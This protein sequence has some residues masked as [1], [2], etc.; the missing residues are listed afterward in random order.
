MVTV[1]RKAKLQG[2]VGERGLGMELRHYREKA[3]LS[4]ERVGEVLG[5]SANTMSRLERGLRPDT[6]TDEVSAILAAIEVYGDD[7][8]RLMRMAVGYSTQG[9]WEGTP[10]LSD[11]ARIYL[12]F[13]TRATR[14]VNVEPLLVPGLLQAPDYMHSLLLAFGVDKSQI[15]GRIARRLG[16]QEIL[17]RR[18]PPELVFVVCERALRDPLGGHV[19][20]ARQ[21][22]HMAEQAERPNVSIRIIPT[23]VVAHP[24][25]RGAFVVLEFDGESPVV[26]IEGRR[27]G[28]FPE[29]PAEVEE[30]RLAAERSTD[31]ALGEQESLDL[32]RAIAEDMERAR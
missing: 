9:W 31:L 5:L 1:S 19:V 29:D 6:T 13:E 21:I 26:H 18:D 17:V 16:R 4:L 15:Y 14:I 28:M 8:D 22:R 23:S 30:Y 32:L 20:M 2:G 25:L 3:G 10:N 24:A 12:K 11:Q 27:S 7:R